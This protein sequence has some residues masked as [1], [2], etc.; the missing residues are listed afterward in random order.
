MTTEAEEFYKAYEDYS[1]TLRTWLVAYG[2]G[3][4]VL[5]LTN[6]RISKVLLTSGNARII[7]G[8]FLAG[9]AI[10]VGITAINKAAMWICYFS[11]EEENR[12]WCN[13]A[14]WLSSQF[15]IDLICDLGTL[16]AFAI[17]T[18]YAFDVLMKA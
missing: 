17:A 7:A 3:G 1:R 10:Q 14:H 9:V 4:P 15:W 18:W 8:F 12:W 5:M 6:D 2:I 16:T 11:E 13:A